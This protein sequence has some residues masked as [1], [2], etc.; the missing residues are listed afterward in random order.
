M[1]VLVVD[2]SVGLKWFL[3]EVHAAA[4]GCP[5]RLPTEVGWHALATRSAA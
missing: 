1:S 2:A 5:N 3:P 4:A